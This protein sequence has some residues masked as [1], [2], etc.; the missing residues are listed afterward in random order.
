MCQ[1]VE[2]MKKRESLAVVKQRRKWKDKG[3]A[4]E[5]GRALCNAHVVLQS[6]KFKSSQL[7]CNKE[8]IKRIEKCTT[9][10]IIATIVGNS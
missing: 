3:M 9:I 10:K 6:G 5:E 1:S 2:I 8:K 7:D 4:W